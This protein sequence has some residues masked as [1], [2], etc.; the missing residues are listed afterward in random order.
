MCI[1]LRA[2]SHLRATG[3]HLPYTRHKW[4]R[5][6][7]TPVSQAICLFV[8]LM[9]PAE[10]VGQN[11]MPFV[12]DTG[13]VPSNIVLDRAPVFLREGENF[14]SEPRSQQCCL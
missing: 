2:L 3:R 10:A 7:L 11:E 13:M 8:T 5:R 1:A 14:R 12:R 9:H 6:T 4:T